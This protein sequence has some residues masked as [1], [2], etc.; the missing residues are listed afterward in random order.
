MAFTTRVSLLSAVRRG[1]EIGSEEFYE[2]YKPLVYLRANDLHLNETEKEDLVQ[3][4]MMD[5][6]GRSKAFVYDKT[7][8]RFRDYFRTIIKHK[9]YDLMRKRHDDEVSIETIQTE[10]DSI[11]VEGEDRWQREWETH[12][13]NQAVLEL[14]NAVSPIV[15]QTFFWNCL[16]SFSPQKT[17]ETLGISVDAVYT[18]KFKAMQKLN[19]LIKSIDE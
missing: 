7:K 8:G 9:A 13:K 16:K 5:F 11:F 12:I 14:R 15:F 10:V 3:L 19:S 2:M 18:N 1:D 17:A 4:V 6:F